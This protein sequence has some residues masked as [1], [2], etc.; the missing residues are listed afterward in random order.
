MEPQASVHIF[1]VVPQTFHAV[2]HENAD[3]T[4]M[5]IYGCCPVLPLKSWWSREG[6]KHGLLPM[7]MFLLVL[8]LGSA[9]NTIFTNGTAS[10]WYGKSPEHP[11]R[12]EGSVLSAVFPPTLAPAFRGFSFG[13]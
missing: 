7:V 3:A 5:L 9:A 13:K 11:A 8:R 4:W 6:V 12:I 10:A 2:F 1:V